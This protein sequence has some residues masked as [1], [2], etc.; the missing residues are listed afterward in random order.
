MLLAVVLAAVVG[1]AELLAPAWVAS[2]A[3]AAV[4]QESGGRVEVD[5][6]VSGPPL[7]V[8]VL[9]SGQ[10]ES[11]SVRLQEV[12]GR[13]L[14]VTVVLD[15]DGVVLDRG[16]LLRGDVTVEAVDDARATVQVDLSGSVPP[17]LQGLADRLA[18]AGLEPLLDALA[19]EGGGEALVL[20][21]LSI[22]LVPASCE[23]TSADLVVT[24]RCELRTVPSFLL[25][26]FD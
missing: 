1:V 18:G 19:G 15:L 6:D 14:P 23:V 25:A 16:R 10:V 12:A 22:P 24:A 17:A 21:E 13:Q 7:L 3:E 26:P 8:P 2:Q 11:W 5:V 9:A 20:G 4:A